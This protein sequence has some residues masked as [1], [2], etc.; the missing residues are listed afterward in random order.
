MTFSFTVPT[1]HDAS[2]CVQKNQGRFALDSVTLAQRDGKTFLLAT[3]GHV[4]A[5][6][7][8]QCAEPP[9]KPLLLPS[10][11]SKANGKPLT[12][13]V[14]GEVRITSGK[15]TSVL[16]LPEQAGRFPALKDLMPA[17][18]ALTPR[19]VIILDAR[20][21]ANLAKAISV[22]GHVA[23]FIPEGDRMVSKPIVVVGMDENRGIGLLMPR[24]PNAPEVER[25]QA[26]YA[27]IVQAM[28]LD[29]IRFGTVDA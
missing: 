28:P 20:E 7:P 10:E 4:L 21:L 22:D 3:D 2:Q 23:L 24:P 12:V 18:E 15:K 8:V 13:E 27:D 11:A 14:N 1:G 19:R 26:H 29:G 25:V 16:P 5:V 9:A 17:A 6:Q